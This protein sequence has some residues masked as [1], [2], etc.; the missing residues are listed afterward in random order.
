MKPLDAA[1]RG[2]RE[3][4]MPVTFAIITTVAAFAPL[5]FVSGNMGKIMR[6]IPIVVIAVLLM[7]LVEALLILPAHLSAR[8][9]LV[10]PHLAAAFIGAT[11]RGSR[12]TVQRGLQWV[13]DGRTVD[14]SS[15]RW[16]GATRPSPSPWLFS[17]LS[18]SLVAGGFIKFS[19]MPK[20]DADNMVAL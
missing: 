16:S 12:Q 8:R 5:L 10:Q 15:W 4:A 14:A 20:V 18:V 2:V 7:S 17:S 11:R 1:I 3:M 6:Q 13:I 19:F 9:S